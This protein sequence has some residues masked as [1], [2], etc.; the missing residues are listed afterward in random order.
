MSYDEWKLASPF[1]GQRPTY[2]CRNCD[3]DW[4]GEPPKIVYCYQCDKPLCPKCKQ[5]LCDCDYTFCSECYPAH[6]LSCA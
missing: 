1:E 5:S 6:W 4:Y 2:K 3:T